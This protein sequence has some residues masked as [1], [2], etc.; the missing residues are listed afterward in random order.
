MREAVRRCPDINATTR[1]TLVRQLESA[2]FEAIQNLKNMR[3]RVRRNT[4]INSTTRYELMRQIERAID[5]AERY[6]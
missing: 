2:I 4:D 5:A 1:D 3:E 6:Y